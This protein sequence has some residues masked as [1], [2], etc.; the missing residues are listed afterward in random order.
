MVLWSSFECD[1]K[2]NNDIAILLV[3]ALFNWTSCK[4]SV[5][6][7]MWSDKKV[8]IMNEINYKWKLLCI[9]NRM[10][11]STIWNKW[12]RLTYCFQFCVT[13]LSNSPCK[14]EA[15]TRQGM[16]KGANF[17]TTLLLFYHTSDW[18]NQPNL[19]KHEVAAYLFIFNWSTIFISTKSLLNLNTTV[20]LCGEHWKIGG[21]YCLCLRLPWLVEMFTHKENYLS[22]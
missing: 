4:I 13:D 5:D 3:E 19:P 9:E 20:I 18:L 17:C 22:E 7:V 16:Q 6:E 1:Y 15:T 2:A 11:P 8:W 12:A 21:F 14:K 10:I